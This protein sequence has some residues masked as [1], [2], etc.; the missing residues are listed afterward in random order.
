MTVSALPQNMNGFLF[1]KS[2]LVGIVVIF[3][4]AGIG[5]LQFSLDTL[6][7]RPVVQIESL[8]QLPKG[9]YLKPASL[10]YHHLGPIC[11][12]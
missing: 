7:D 5:W 12:G 11:F 6:H 9:Q 8:A 4:L 3:L 2:S 10:G 1:L